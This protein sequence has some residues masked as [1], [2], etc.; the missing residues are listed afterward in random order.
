M[1]LEVEQSV[2]GIGLLAAFLL[3]FLVNVP[4]DQ[5]RSKHIMS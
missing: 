2:I 4:T 3:L 1:D 5:I